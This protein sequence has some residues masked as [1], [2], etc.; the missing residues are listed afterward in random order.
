[1]ICIRGRNLQK[2]FPVRNLPA[3]RVHH[4]PA[5]VPDYLERASRLVKSNEFVHARIRPHCFLF[6][7]RWQIVAFNR[8]NEAH[9]YRG[10]NSVARGFLRRRLSGDFEINERPFPITRR[11]RTGRDRRSSYRGTQKRSGK[12]VVGGRGE[13][14]NRRR[15]LH[16]RAIND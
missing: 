10:R 6:N 14:A 7:N 12:G 13:N 2:L 9:R 8:A 15:D 11:L 4:C 3:K 5:L 16:G 1:M